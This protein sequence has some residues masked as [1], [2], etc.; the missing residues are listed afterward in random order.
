MAQARRAPGVRSERDAV[1]QRARRNPMVELPA[2]Q[3][4]RELDPSVRSILRT[5]L[6]DLRSDARRRAEKSGRTRKP[7]MAAYWAAVAAYAGH[8]ARLL[9]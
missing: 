4:L 6:L 7:P 5:L 9:R 1:S 2:A 3:A 8:L